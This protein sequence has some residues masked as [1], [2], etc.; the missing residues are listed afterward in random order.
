[1]SVPK[2]LKTLRRNDRI[3]AVEAVEGH[4]K[5]PLVPT[6]DLDRDGLIEHNIYSVNKGWSKNVELLWNLPNIE[7]D[8]DYVV[9]E[10]HVRFPSSPLITADFR[11]R[12]QKDWYE[13]KFGEEPPWANG[14]FTCDWF[15]GLRKEYT[16]SL[17]KDF[18]HIQALTAQNGII[19]FFRPELD[20]AIQKV[21]I[22]RTNSKGRP[23]KAKNP[24]LK[25]HV[26]KQLRKRGN[27]SS[28]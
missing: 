17:P 11:L 2:L 3:F 27:F 14:Y 7:T 8:Q 16:P 12:R 20:I 5:R 4:G 15:R 21:D 26:E 19:H 13:R 23:V 6:V 1:M 25:S 10:A 24:W 28:V 9:F 18:P 22:F